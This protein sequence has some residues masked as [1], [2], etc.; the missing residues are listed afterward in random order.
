MKT[1]HVL[2]TA[3]LAL[4]A[5][6]A[7]SALA[8]TT[9][10]DD[11]AYT[12]GSSINT[13]VGGTGTWAA[14]AWAGN[15]TVTTT[16]LTYGSLQ[17]SGNAI[18]DSS[19]TG[20]RNA[21]RTTG[22]TINTATY[23][24]SFLVETVTAPTL[25]VT[26]LFTFQTSSGTTR[27]V[28]GATAAGNWTLGTRDAAGDPATGNNDGNLATIALSGV[29]LITYRIDVGAGTGGTSNLYVWVNP[30]IGGAEPTIGG[31]GFLGS[32]TNTD[33]FASTANFN[34]LS[35]DTTGDNAA[36]LRID[37]IRFGDTFSAVTPVPEPEV[38]A[39]LGGLTALSL[40]AFARRRNTR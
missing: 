25:A 40:A 14:N 37:E 29:Q 7:S 34:K 19:A 21:S 2:R 10:S 36:R 22:L 6:A 26:N 28:L 23:W 9:L 16:G 38:T 3:L 30:A 15:M 33:A 18:E 1:A 4:P 8:Q 35:I 11:F 39:L 24:G 17:V 13:L 12:S 31:A 20:S 32:A 27:M 5:L